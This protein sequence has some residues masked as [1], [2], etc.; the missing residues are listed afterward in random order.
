MPTAVKKSRGVD[1]EAE[2]AALGQ[3]SKQV[4]SYTKDASMPL[5]WHTLAS[6]FAAYMKIATKKDFPSFLAQ[7]LA[8]LRRREEETQASIQGLQ[9]IL[10]D[11]R[12]KAKTRM[13][14]NLE[15]GLHAI[16]AIFQQNTYMDSSIRQKIRESMMVV[17]QGASEDPISGD[18]EVELIKDKY[19]KL[20]AEICR[21]LGLLYSP[22]EE[23]V[24]IEDSDDEA[25]AAAHQVVVVV[26]TEDKATSTDI[27]SQ[28]EDE[29]AEVSTKPDTDSRRRI[30]SR[31]LSAT[32]TKRYTRFSDD[33]SDD[34]HSAEPT[35]TTMRETLIALQQKVYSFMKTEKDPIAKQKLGLLSSRL[36]A[37]VCN[38]VDEFLTLS[39]AYGDFFDSSNTIL[40]EIAH[41]KA[42]ASLVPDA[43][44]YH[45][46]NMLI[47]K[48][49]YK[50]EPS[51][52]ADNSQVLKRCAAI[53]G[54]AESRFT[55]EKNTF[56][57]EIGK[58][59]QKTTA[60]LSYADG[61]H[62]VM[63]ALDTTSTQHT[64]SISTPE[65]RLAAIGG[66]IH[67]ILT[68]DIGV[69]PSKRTR[70]KTIEEPQQAALGETIEALERNITTPL[71]RQ[72]DSRR[73]QLELLLVL[74]KYT[75]DTIAKFWDP[76]MR[77]QYLS[78]ANV[79]A[80]R[81][82]VN[83][84]ISSTASAGKAP[85][86]L[87][88][89]TE[90]VSMLCDTLFNTMEATKRSVED[91][92]VFIDKLYI[93]QTSNI[94]GKE[95]QVVNTI[96]LIMHE[97]KDISLVDTMYCMYLMHTVT[98]KSLSKLLFP[99]KGG[100][101]ISN[102]V[103]AIWAA[104]RGAQQPVE[105]AVASDSDSSTPRGPRKARRGGRRIDSSDEEDEAVPNIKNAA[106]GKLGDAPSPKA[107]VAAGKTKG[108]P[109]KDS[110]SS[111]GYDKTNVF[112]SIIRSLD[113]KVKTHAAS[114]SKDAH[115]AKAA[116][117][118]I[119]IAIIK[120][121]NK[122]DGIDK[123]DIKKIDI[124]AYI[125]LRTAETIRDYCVEHEATFDIQDVEKL[126]L[127]SQKI[128]EM[129][130]RIRKNTGK[131]RAA[132]DTRVAEVY[133]GIDDLY[134][135]FL[136]DAA[137]IET[138]TVG[139]KVATAGASKKEKAD[140]PEWI[141]IKKDNLKAIKTQLVASNPDDE[142]IRKKQEK[143]LAATEELLKYLR[144]SKKGR[145]NP[146]IY[147]AMERAFLSNRHLLLAS[148][149]QISK[150]FD[151]IQKTELRLYEKG[152]DLFKAPA[153]GAAK[154]KTKND[155]VVAAEDQGDD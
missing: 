63:Q 38:H 114:G 48:H 138:K 82:K 90:T 19:Q 10:L 41:S 134:K 136:S 100:K 24:Q 112:D 115:E 141:R 46:V 108:Q 60:K 4:A 29:A 20:A 84:I 87:G 16:I 102:T 75:D 27:N 83:E 52:D 146:V 113:N 145:D 89:Y 56:R 51:T 42:D 148:T 106:G 135:K 125:D 110:R 69:K 21:D 55:T 11:I 73:F 79:A 28:T 116:I 65:D 32:G 121:K 43:R 5:M 96:S 93:Q 70:T 143:T 132:V 9:K 105:D 92:A 49:L 127:I 140:D 8:F 103:N 67:E 144:Y 36:D 35:T 64:I 80:F 77:K 13:R 155:T 50:N 54:R 142:E 98:N 117:E 133:K 30:D 126:S 59:L 153:A 57:G 74:S 15:Y 94:H 152:A 85:D 149:D 123:V 137:A 17:V 104:R 34:G 101:D 130:N 120:I 3:I 107:A 58:V 86:Y 66:I 78:D 31:G 147:A 14:Y 109:N 150:M 53:L 62:L 61:Y 88:L 139:K 131:T 18:A 25:A 129:T 40:A 128:T 44:I 119:K 37:D 7:Q 23:I 45:D 122:M 81:G 91:K 12:F 72:P 124:K 76:A 26:D 68:D 6:L 33:N 95:A 39:D 71:G 22:H 47:Y 151:T 2:T 111:G 154:G 1:I 118:G 99:T 97:E